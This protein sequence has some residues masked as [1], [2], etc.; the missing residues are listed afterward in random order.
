[1]TTILRI[2]LKDGRTIS[3]RTDIAKGNPADPMSYE[4]VA[5]K[6]LDCASFAKWPQAKA[7]QIVGMVR[8]LEDV[9]DVRALTAL[10]SS[11]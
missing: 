5:A 11:V 1:M 4:E 6:F 9:T 8:R 2:K 10:C 3:G 7:K